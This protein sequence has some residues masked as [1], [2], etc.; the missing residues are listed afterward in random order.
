MDS[1]LADV[2]ICDPAIGSGAFPM[3][4]L[5]L[6]FACRT[7]L[8]PLLESQR[9]AA[10]LKRHIIRHNI[11]GVDIERGAVDIARL[12]FWLALVVDAPEPLPLPH[13]DY[14]IMQGDSLLERIADVDL[15]HIA[16]AGAVAPPV[17]QDLFGT[18]DLDAARVGFATAEACATFRRNLERAFDT[19]DHEERLRLRTSLHRRVASAVSWSLSPRLEQ[20]RRTLAELTAAAASLTPRQRKEA[21]RLEAFVARLEPIVTYIATHGELPPTEC[22]LWH[23]WFRDV[24]EREG[25]AGFDIVIGNPPYIQLQA[26]SSLL[27]T[28]YAE[29][30]FVTL[31]KRGDIYSLFCELSRRLLAPGGHLCLITSNKWMRAA[32]GA[33]TRRFLAAVDTDVLQL[34][35][36]AGTKLFEN[37]T[38]D[39]N[40]LLAAASPNRHATQAL[41]VTPELRACLTDSGVFRRHAA[42]MAFPADESWVAL[43]PRQQRRSSPRTPTN[44]SPQSTNPPRRPKLSPRHRIAL[45]PSTYRHTPSAADHRKIPTV[46]RAT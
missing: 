14:K 27:A 32:Y 2:K 15:S 1:A 35:D 8:T 16:E 37:A 18:V 30:G 29:G 31:N 28:R 45:S 26:N 19:G 7:A 9:T 4:L 38:V 17:R 22:F 33:E 12:R 3:G 5:R 24:F 43:Q 42:C 23:T 44:P 41:T 10:D 21:A 39:A 34:L 40:I 13:L 36:F 25:R 46:G 20:A 11:Y 6:L